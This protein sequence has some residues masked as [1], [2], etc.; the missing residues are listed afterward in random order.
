MITDISSPIKVAESLLAEYKEH[1]SLAIA[2]DFDNTLYD[3]HK[4]NLS[5]I[6]Q[7]LD[8]LEASVGLFDVTIW[9]CSNEERHIFIQDYLY[10]TRNI[11]PNNYLINDQKP[12]YKTL[13][14]GATKPF[15]SL[16]LDDRSGL[17]FT[18]RVLTYLLNNLN[19]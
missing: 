16:L 7:I 3:L 5:H 12:I 19:K 18:I 14:N 17:S 1:G 10:R 4:N 9:T 2:F 11:A 6:N 13:T 15:F 8:L